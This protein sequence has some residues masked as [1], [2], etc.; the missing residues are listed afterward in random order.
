MNIE[1][2]L[3]N[4]WKIMNNKKVNRKE[5]KYLKINI[6]KITFL[7]RINLKMIEKEE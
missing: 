3:N 6:Y 4:K 1:D 7:K 5:M 2:K